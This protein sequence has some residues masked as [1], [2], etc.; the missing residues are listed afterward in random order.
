MPDRT[1]LRAPAALLL[2]GTVAYIAVT[3]LHTAG[4][5]NDHPE[6]FGD[7]A[8]SSTWGVVHLGQFAAM[9]VI[10]AG[11][12]TLISA[13]RRPDTPDRGLGVGAV[14]AGIAL[15][16]YGV[17]QAVDGVA[18]KHAVDA[19]VAAP[20]SDKAARYASAETVRWLE[21]GARSYHDLA[22]GLAL[23]ALAVGARTLPRTLAALIA[24]SGLVYATQGWIVGAG[25]FS[26]DESIAILIGFALMLTWTSWLTALAWRPVRTSPPARLLHTNT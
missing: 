11:L 1:T 21:W 25:G 7:Y 8:A 18:L 24:L 23:L 19:W 6:I 22:L 13:L 3:M 12:L 9:T 20:E 4:P 15:G 5:A 17:L 14:L 26:D 10:V 2:G 16:L